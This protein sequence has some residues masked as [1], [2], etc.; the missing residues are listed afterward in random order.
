MPMKI[1]GLMGAFT[2]TLFLLCSCSGSPTLDTTSS[3][4]YKQTLQKMFDAQKDEQARIEL[5]NSI[6]SV[7][8]DG[9]DWSLEDSKK[10]YDFYDVL[11]GFGASGRLMPLNGKN[12]DEIL[13]MGYEARKKWVL[14]NIP[15]QIKSVQEKIT[16]LN[17]K[18]LNSEKIEST[19]KLFQL[20]DVQLIPQE[21]LEVSSKR[22]LGGVSSF[23]ITGKGVN[24]GSVPVY[25][26]K[27]MVTVT[28]S[29][30]NSR[31]YDKGNFTLKFSSPIEPNGYQ[32]FHKE[33]SVWDWR[34]V[35]YEKDRYTLQYT[36]TSANA[37][38]H[39]NNL[40]MSDVKFTSFDMRELTDLENSLAEYTTLLKKFSNS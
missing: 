11:N 35:P 7:A 37:S 14:A 22:P 9:Q 2:F 10:G 6:S 20:E 27:V 1:V 25:S 19:E 30:N 17:E 33:L 5:A 26:C 29:K 39:A 3:A 13:K 32:E 40:F 8:T 18:K 28:D 16:K 15:P 21:A 24:K 31:I 4:A 38:H 36:L 12:A 34:S 23:I